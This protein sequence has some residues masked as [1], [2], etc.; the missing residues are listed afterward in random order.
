MSLMARLF[1]TIIVVS[2]VVIAVIAVITEATKEW[3]TAEAACRGFA[4]GSFLVMESRIVVDLLMTIT[5]QQT[6]SVIARF[7]AAIAMINSAN[8]ADHNLLWVSNTLYSAYFAD[9][10]LG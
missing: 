9:L 2:P 7:I 1:T 5:K 3:Y 6:S 4:I 10:Y 8:L